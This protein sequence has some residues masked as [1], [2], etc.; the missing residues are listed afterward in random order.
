MDR[1]QNIEL[2]ICIS[3]M[4]ETTLTT[5]FY[6]A[7]PFWSSKNVSAFHGGGGSILDSRDILFSL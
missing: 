4:P 5:T 3:L 1:V 2:F 6:L 7:A